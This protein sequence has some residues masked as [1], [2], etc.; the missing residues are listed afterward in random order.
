MCAEGYG[1]GTKWIWETG[2]RQYQSPS[3]ISAMRY[4]ADLPKPRLKTSLSRRLGVRIPESATEG[5]VK[6]KRKANQEGKWLTGG[7]LHFLSLLGRSWTWEGMEKREKKDSESPNYSYFPLPAKITDGA[8]HTN[9]H[10]RLCSSGSGRESA[11]CFCSFGK[12][13]THCSFAFKPFF[14]FF[15]Y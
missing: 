8:S 11:D 6:L 14:F 15:F 9:I 5:H 1:Q 3:S 2:A 12:M 10:C 4:V 7:M 13:T